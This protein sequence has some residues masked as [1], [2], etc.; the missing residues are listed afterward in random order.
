ML[1]LKYKQILYKFMK[2]LFITKN[3]PPLID[4][5]GEYTYNLAHTF[6]K[7][8][9]KVIIVCTNHSEINTI[10]G[11]I[12]VLP[13]INQWNGKAGTK[14]AKIIRDHAV[15]FV[16]LQY[17][18]HGFHPKGLPFG[19]IALVHEIKK[20]NVKTM[21][22]F[23][24]VCIDYI[25]WN[26][27]RTLFSYGIKYIAK[28][29]IEKSDYVATSIEHY[30]K[31][32]QKFKKEI[33]ISTIH[34]ASNIPKHSYTKE[35][36]EQLKKTVA[37]QGEFIIVFFG[38]RDINNQVK[39][40]KELINEGYKIIALSLGNTYFLQQEY[41]IPTYKT[42]LLNINDISQYFQIADCL[43]L[44]ENEKSGC[45]FKSGSL[46]AGLQHAL[47]I[48][49]NKGYMTESTLVNHYN[50]IFTNNQNINDIKRSIKQL[51]Q[52]KDFRLSISKQAALLG[53]TLT[54][55]K[56][57]TDYMNMLKHDVL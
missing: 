37:P 26:I 12:T 4:G 44:P 22:F 2:V 41:K 57:Y 19:L 23:H 9:H 45:S 54:W 40:I 49:T 10:T 52:N 15:D 56:T 16:S 24:E 11:K 6:V 38:K 17:V 21:T 27:K 8:N 48:L 33:N 1:L 46:A 55:E 13:I 31:R 39:A 47:P 7:H 28:K 51:I 14:I 32:I 3:Y 25:G 36:L 29:I 35:Y 30:T 34:I 42:G 20:T 50:I 43:C 18:P 5:V 53:E